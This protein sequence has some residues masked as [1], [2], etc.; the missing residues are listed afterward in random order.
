MASVLHLKG[1]FI[2][3]VCFSSCVMGIISKPFFTGTF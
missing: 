1:K 3:C 2:G